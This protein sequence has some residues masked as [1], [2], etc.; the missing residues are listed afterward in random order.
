MI[1]R[2]IRFAFGWI[3]KIIGDATSAACQVKCQFC[4]MLNYFDCTIR[5]RC[6]IFAGTLKFA[7]IR[8]GPHCK[9]GAMWW[10]PS[11]SWF[12]GESCTGDRDLGRNIESMGIIAA[13]Y[14]CARCNVQ[15]NYMHCLNFRY[16][17]QTLLFI[18]ASQMMNVAARPMSMMALTMEIIQ[19]LAHFVV[20]LHA[21][22]DA[23]A[24]KRYLATMKFNLTYEICIL[25]MC[26]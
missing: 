15:S 24:P 12:G 4:H 11:V 26:T 9:K 19:I 22:I 8:T 16:I 13:K 10:R 3:T 18:S 5:W 14:E 7:Q 25:C 23:P 17:Q 2:S 6:I 1:Y 21:Y 20:N